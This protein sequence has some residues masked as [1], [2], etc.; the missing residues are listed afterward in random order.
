MS[1]II[2]NITEG[3]KPVGLNQYEVLIN[4]K[5][6][7]FFDHDRSFEGL[8]QCLRDAAD[9]VEALGEREDGRLTSDEVDELVK[10][11]GEGR[12]Q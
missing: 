11:L 5:H 2:H 10:K 12:N 3:H 9:A 7:C 4:R 6:I 1:I 8:A